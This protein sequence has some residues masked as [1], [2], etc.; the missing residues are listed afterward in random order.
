MRRIIWLVMASLALFRPQVQ[1]LSQAAETPPPET[2]LARMAESYAAASSYQDTGVVETVVEGT[3]PRRSTD[4]SF[5]TTFKRPRKLRFELKDRDLS[6]VSEAGEPLVA[7]GRYSVS[8]GGG[9]PDTEA[10]AVAGKFQVKGT[11]ALPE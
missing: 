6:M 5:K 10:P 11:K 7:E 2:I 4:V 9:Q 1:A 3:A 8:V